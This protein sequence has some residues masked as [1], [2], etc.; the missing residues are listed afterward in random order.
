MNG[1]QNLGGAL[2]RFPDDYKTAFPEYKKHIRPPRWPRAE[3]GAQSATYCASRN[4]MGVFDHERCLGIP[5]VDE[6]T[7]VAFHVQETVKIRCTN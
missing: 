7:Y 3:T 6:D 5:V 4:G 1:T 2:T